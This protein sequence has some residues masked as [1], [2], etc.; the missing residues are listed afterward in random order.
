[1]LCILNK[2]NTTIHD[3]LV[4]QNLLC[5]KKIRSTSNENV[6]QFLI[7]KKCRS[8]SNEDA[9]RF[10]TWGKFESTSKEDADPFLI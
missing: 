10:L 9:N 1:M 5:K 4:F 3:P 2:T 8:A 6:N 7:W